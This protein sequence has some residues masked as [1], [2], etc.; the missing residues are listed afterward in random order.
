MITDPEALE[1]RRQQRKQKNKSAKKQ[2]LILLGAGVLVAV[3]VVTGILFWI[4]GSSGKGADRGPHP[5]DTVIHLAA[6]GDLVVSDRVVDM[7]TGDYDYTQAFLDV[8]YLLGKADISV[9]NFEGNLVGS[10]YG[11]KYASAPQSLMDALDNAGVDLIQLANSYSIYNGMS[12]LRATIDGVRAAGMEPL[13]VYADAKSFEKS[14]GYTLCQVEDIRIAFVAFTK[15]M[16]GTTL[17]AGSEN[18]VNLLYTDYDSDYQV[19]DTR[20][21]ETILS[22]VKQEKP[23]LTVALVH[24]GS[25]FNATLSV[26]QQQSCRLMQENGVDA[27]IGTHSHY[28][29]AMSLE[30]G[31]FL[32][33]SLGDFLSDPT[34]AGSEYS[35]VLDLEITKSV[36]TGKTQITGYSYTPIFRADNGKTLEL[37]RIQEAMAAF[38]GSYIQK[39]SQADYDAMQYALKRIEARINE[40]P[41][42]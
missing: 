30:D 11:S 3:L 32:A 33:W 12:G 9:L 20:R 40:K 6:A 41:K 37:L 22:N 35:V 10:P 42:S 27:I 21:I 36:N 34:K 31:K 26:S 19:V 17:P 25:E 8:G 4:F 2:R 38:E 24:W 23:D 16:D 39:I 14:G 28:V 15:G 5:D 29:Q 7:A 1:K 18:C 13:G